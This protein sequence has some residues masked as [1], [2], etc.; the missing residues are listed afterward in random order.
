M[1]LVGISL[2]VLW[3]WA[4]S[5]EIFIIQLRI[6]MG[7][8]DKFSV[9]TKP[10]LIFMCLTGWTDLIIMRLW[11]ISV[12]WPPFFI[13]LN[14]P[15]IRIDWLVID[16]SVSLGFEQVSTTQLLREQFL[17]TNITTTLFFKKRNATL[18]GIKYPVTERINLPYP[19]IQHLIALKITRE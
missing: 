13:I 15:L 10:L 9:M 19:W 14:R 8:R 3:V 16:R 1:R 11:D 2:I 17:S 6:C 7:W 12:E 5:G 18:A 4:L